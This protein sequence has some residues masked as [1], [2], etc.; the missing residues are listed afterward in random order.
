MP[1]SQLLDNCASISVAAILPAKRRD[2][3][4]GGGAQRSV[5]RLET[6]D[7]SQTVYSS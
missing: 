5:G 1:T 7:F 2:G 6:S 3:V 4:K